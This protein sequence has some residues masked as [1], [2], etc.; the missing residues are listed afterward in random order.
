MINP[1]NHSGLRLDNTVIGLGEQQEREISERWKFEAI[2]DYVYKT[3]GLPMPTE[4]VNPYP[5]LTIDDL[6]TTDGKRYTTK[7]LHQIEWAGWTGRK[8]GEVEAKL[9]LVKA[10]M[11][12]IARGIRINM[13]KHC[14]RKNAKGQP[15][16]PTAQEMED[17]IGSDLRHK[18]LF[19]EHAFLTALLKM[20]NSEEKAQEAKTGLIS[21][22]VEIRRQEFDNTNRGGSIQGK[23]G[24]PNSDREPR[25]RF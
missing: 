7:F 23:R 12:E 8:T 2:T 11:E 15:K 1:P 22:Q 21:R 18:E 4:P 19:R 9:I 5:D 16:P 3:L 14:T 17:E 13:R 10:E 25:R 6:T 20:L 24:I